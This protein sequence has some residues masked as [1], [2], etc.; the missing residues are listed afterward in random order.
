MVKSK[1][2]LDEELCLYCECT[3]YGDREI[4]TNPHNMC[5]GV[6]CDIAYDNYLDEEGE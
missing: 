5:G 2:D 3:D 4:N 6:L 1:D